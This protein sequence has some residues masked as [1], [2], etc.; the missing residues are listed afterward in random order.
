MRWKA[1]GAL[2]VLLALAGTTATGADLVSAAEAGD[3]AAVRAQ[4]GSGA[5]V[6]AADSD[7]TTA[8]HWAAYLGNLDM[9]QALVT[10]GADASAQNAFNKLKIALRP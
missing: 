8:L 3:T 4:L 2:A 6:N 9:A 7:G 10:A 5:N 1:I